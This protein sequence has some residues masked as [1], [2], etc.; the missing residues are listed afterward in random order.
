[1]SPH[2]RAVTV[3]VDHQSLTLRID[4]SRAGL[5]IR[6]E[7]ILSQSTIHDEI[8]LEI[9]H[10]AEDQPSFKLIVTA[11]GFKDALDSY[12]TY[13]DRRSGAGI[14]RALRRIPLWGW[15]VITAIVAP[16]MY[17]VLTTGFIALHVIVPVE[18]EAALGEAVYNHLMED[19]QFQPCTDDRLRQE[20]QNMVD[21]LVDPDSPYE[22][23]VTVVETAMPNAFALPGGRIVVLSGLLK[24]SSSDAV[25]GVLAHEIAHVECR[26]SMKQ[27]F[28][29]MG[30]MYFMGAAVGGGFEELELAET[31]AELSGVLLVLRHSRAAETEADQ[32][33]AR[34][35]HED[36][37]S[38][39]GLIEFFEY[40]ETIQGPAELHQALLWLSTHPLTEHRL[41]WLRA[42]E[43]RETFDPVPWPTGGAAWEDLIEGCQVEEKD[44]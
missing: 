7:H 36:R 2:A 18:A 39:K 29:A 16:T 19:P 9:D 10:P 33:A 28:R 5:E 1:M 40:V 27:L 34:K 6:P 21:E 25:L 17:W 41:D 30:V 22:C 35:L 32:V 8:H 11:P 26:H 15:V 24:E 44:G 3:V 20:L 38:V 23:R 37:R 12:L 43:R 4:G 13:S 14:G 42:E 31:V